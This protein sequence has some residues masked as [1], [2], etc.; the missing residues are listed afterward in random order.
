MEIECACAVRLRRHAYLLDGHR[1]LTRLARA[2]LEPAEGVSL[3]DAPD[4]EDRIDS[5]IHDLV[6]EDEARLPSQPPSRDHMLFMASIGVESSKSHQA[7]QRFNAL[8]YAIRKTFLLLCLEGVSIEDCV[9]R[10][11]GL[12]DTL[13]RAVHQCFQALLRDWPIVKIPRSE[14]PRLT[15]SE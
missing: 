9:A 6:I 15:G 1:V 5:A 7:G 4:L 12:T 11:M 2:A 13:G 14:Q 8:P 10:G 3:G